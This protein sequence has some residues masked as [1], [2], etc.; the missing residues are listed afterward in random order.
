[1]TALM[2]HYI[3]T[4]RHYSHLQMS[5]DSAMELQLASDFMRDS[6]RHAGF[7]P[8]LNVNLLNPFDH[9]EGHKNIKALEATSELR[10]NRMSPYFNVILNMSASNHLTATRDTILHPTQLVMIADCYHA[11][12]LR[13]SSVKQTTSTQ[14]VTLNSSL[15]FL[16]EP[17]VYIGEWLEERFFVPSKEGLFYQR[18]HTDELTSLVKTIS[19]KRHNQMV[20]VQLGLDGDKSLMLASRIR[21]Q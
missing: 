15:N 10:V 9:R 14:A 4:K 13:I 21:A 18:E 1:M 8:C 19:I 2:N 6:I 5:L 11:E 7:S 3:S 20:E 17:P 12:I 16:Y